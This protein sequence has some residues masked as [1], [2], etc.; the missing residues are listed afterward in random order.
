MTT[1]SSAIRYHDFDDDSDDGNNNN[2]NEKEKI[3]IHKQSNINDMRL[4]S[5]DTARKRAKKKE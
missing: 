5:I 4:K 1:F 2:N 3:N